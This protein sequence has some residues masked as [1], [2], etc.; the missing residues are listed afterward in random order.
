MSSVTGQANELAGQGHA[1]L[2][3]LLNTHPQ[4]G[5]FCMQ[6]LKLRL[7][8]VAVWLSMAARAMGRSCCYIPGVA[9]QAGT[10]VGQPMHHLSQ[11]ILQCPAS[12]Q[13]CGQR[14]Y[15]AD[16]HVLSKS[17]ED[18]PCMNA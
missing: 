12:S 6:L 14:T 4:H 17:E 2:K 10:Q 9:R 1:M 5:N 15:N 3:P 7:Q 8:G 18:T 11:L 13:M 16:T